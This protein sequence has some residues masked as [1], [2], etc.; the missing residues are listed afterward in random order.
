[1]PPSTA[2]PRSTAMPKTARSP[3]YW[4]A[5]SGSRRSRCENCSTASA[6]FLER[7]ALVEQHHVVPLRALRLVH[8]QHVAV[9]KLVIGFALLPGDAIDPAFEAILAHRD[10]CHLVAEHLVR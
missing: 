1:M 2:R 9:V 7:K 3:P 4:R 6:T 8:G 5:R 10:F